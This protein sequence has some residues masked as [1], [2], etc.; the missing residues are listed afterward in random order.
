MVFTSLALAADPTETVLFITNPLPTDILTGKRCSVIVS[1]ISP[2]PIVSGSTPWPFITYPETSVEFSYPPSVVCNGTT[3][4]RVSVS[5]SNPVTSGAAGSDPVVVTGYYAIPDTTAPTI[6]DNADMTVEGNTTGGANVIYTAPTATDNVDPNPSVSCSPA[7]GSFFILGGPTAVTCTATDSSNNSSSNSFDVTVVDT[8]APTLVGMPANMTVESNTMGGANV[9]YIAPT[10]T[11][12]VDANPF[13]SCT[14]PSGSL[15][16][17]GSTTVNCSAKDSSGNTRPGSFNVTVVD[18]TLPTITFV[19]R[20]PAANAFGWNDTNVTVTWSCSDNVGV[21]SPTVTQVVTN[22]GSSL[23]VTGTCTDTSGNATPD[24]QTGINIDKTAPSLSPVVSP[25]PVILNGSAIVN[26]NASDGLSG[27]DAVNCGAL[28]TSSVGSKSVTCTAT[29]KAGNFNSVSV[30]YSV[31]YAAPGTD[32]NGVPGHQILQPI[33]ADNSSVFKAGSTVPA[34]FR[35]CGTDGV[36]IATAGVVESFD[37]IQIISNSTVSDFNEEVDS[38]TPDTEFRTGNG[39]WI[40]NINTKD[41]VA[42]NTYIYR[43]TLNDGSNIQF[44]FD[45]K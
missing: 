20:L 15:F 31:R 43:I 2:E 45:L 26:A 25:N 22:E 24:T 39:Q 8:T 16:L 33:N 41:L 9:T 10:A 32:C 17:I 44:Q 1:V 12:I 23:S 14:P 37:L 4:N 11:D 18:T 27:L 29:D 13:V 6:T 42:G 34:K 3:Y 7:S 30:S 28:D 36:P 35:V 38:T 5:P 40:F 21:L 19:S